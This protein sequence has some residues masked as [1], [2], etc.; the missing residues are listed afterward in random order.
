MTG[1]N[2]GHGD[3]ARTVDR[4][5]DV[6]TSL[7]S[8]RDVRETHPGTATA[9]VDPAP[10]PRA[11][12]DVAASLASAMLE[13]RSAPPHE[14]LAARVVLAVLEGR[15]RHALT[16]LEPLLDEPVRVSAFGS[17][18]EELGVHLA[19]A[20]GDER[21][22]ARCSARRDAYHQ[23]FA[24]GHAVEALAVLAAE[25][26]WL[27]ALDDLLAPSDV[28]QTADATGGQT[29]EPVAAGA[30]YDARWGSPGDDRWTLVPPP[31]DPGHVGGF[32]PLAGEADAPGRDG[33]MAYLV[34]LHHLEDARTADFSTHRIGWHELDSELDG[35][36]DLVLSFEPGA[37]AL[38]RGVD[39]D[40]LS[41][42]LFFG[43]G[44]GYDEVS[45]GMGTLYDVEVNPAE[46]RIYL[47]LKRPTAWAATGLSPAE[48]WR[49]LS[50]CVLITEAE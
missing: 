4:L 50:S 1:T 41:L 39:P 9:V 27:E 21:F 30:A 3:G 6:A 48:L 49:G 44:T 14:A 13:D 33:A 11:V 28:T 20:V 35:I 43:D 45:T 40:S 26:A 12:L 7:I 15:I 23:R 25:S 36:S 24:A 22:G 46:S 42:R 8:A 18:L 37:E 31:D 38:L 47:K 17:R 19:A 5:L 10:P 16:E 32:V 2:G 29:P 34:T